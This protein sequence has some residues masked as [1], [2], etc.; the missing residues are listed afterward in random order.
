M[1]CEINE[2]FLFVK[3]DR[4]GT[5]ACAKLWPQGTKTAST[6]GLMPCW[7]DGIHEHVAITDLVSSA[8]LCSKPVCGV[9]V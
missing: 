7:M 3:N 5:K 1:V 6:C 4:E 2:Q 9:F 8:T